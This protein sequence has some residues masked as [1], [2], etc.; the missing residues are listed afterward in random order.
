MNIDTTEN[1]NFD[2]DSK[3]RKLDI[4]FEN[5]KI[6]IESKKSKMDIDSCDRKN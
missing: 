1:I 4:D 5:I 3:K 6:D 2:I